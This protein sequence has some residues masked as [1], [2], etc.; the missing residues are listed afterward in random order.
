MKRH[1]ALSPA[2]LA[3]TLIAASLIAGSPPTAPPTPDAASAYL[4]DHPGGTKINSNELQYGPIVVTVV[5]PTAAGTAD[6]PSGWF[7]FYAGRNYT[8]PRGRL[9]S[10]GPQ[11]LARYGWANRV[12]S[13]YYDLGSGS[14]T[15]YDKAKA[16]DPND[17]RRL[18]TVSAG[19][20]GDPDTAPH[21]DKADYIYRICPRSVHTVR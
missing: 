16:S 5:Q 15:F 2:L 17:D 20:R 1:H 13:A 14:V 4:L 7:C 10:C 3:S 8:F 12:E 18:F 6:C 11:N 21:R 9:S 19:T